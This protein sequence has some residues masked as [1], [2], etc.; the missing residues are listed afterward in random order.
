MENWTKMNKAL[1]KTV[2]GVPDHLKEFEA[3]CDAAP[4]PSARAVDFISEGDEIYLGP[5][6]YERVVPEID[7]HHTERLCLLWYKDPNNVG[8]RYGL[9]W[10]NIL[11]T[12]R[13][14]KGEVFKYYKYS[15]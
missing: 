5:V 6:I 9:T 15:H 11:V 13:S 2:T 4:P 7:C 3:W 12:I 1:E 14:S 8:A 10:H